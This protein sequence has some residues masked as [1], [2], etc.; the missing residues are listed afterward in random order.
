MSATRVTW[1]FNAPRDRVY[2]ALVTAG[3]VAQWKFPSGMTCDI[4]EFDSREGGRVR[5]SLTYDAT[6][7]EGKTRGRTDT[8]I[9]RFVTLVP[10]EILVEVDEFETTDPALSGEMTTTIRLTDADDGGTELFAVHDGLPPGVSE[11][12]NEIGWREALSRLAQ[13]VEPSASDE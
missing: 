11:A 9:G 3:D 5:I 12:D 1:Q 7:R 8:Y 2:A 10:N 4:H 6:D 13:L